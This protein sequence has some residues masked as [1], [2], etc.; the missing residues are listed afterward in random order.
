MGIGFSG[1]TAPTE[2]SNAETE[3]PAA[4]ETTESNGPTARSLDEV[5]DAYIK[6]ADAKDHDAMVVLTDAPWLDV[7]REIVRSRE[8]LPKMVE[9]AAPQMTPAAGR[10]IDKAQY[11]TIRDELETDADR[12]L[13]DE[14]LRLD[15][16]IVTI[17]ADGVPKRFLLVRIR[18]DV[19]RVV[20]GPLKLNQFL[21]KN[22][23]PYTIDY[24]L[25]VSDEFELFSL[26]PN[27]PAADTP[28][29]KLFYGYKVLD[30][31]VVTAAN[32]RTRIADAVRRGIEDNEGDAKKCFTPRYALR[33]SDPSDVVDLI[34]S[35][36]CRVINVYV[37]GRS[38]ADV[39]TTEA[40]VDVLNSFLEVRA[41]LP[42][43]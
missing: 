41:P 28:P 20:A 9:R 36:E 42:G 10:K 40:P 8:R 3:K 1:C 30:K 29:K 11:K 26:D 39:L 32:D 23:M 25:D 22:R 43:K 33:M 2:P 38:R 34:F 19:A 16:W 13:F 18:N 4:T 35:F 14:L 21:P 31:S 7:R 27:P 6:A 5:I 24:M 15:D 12:A 17:T 37:N